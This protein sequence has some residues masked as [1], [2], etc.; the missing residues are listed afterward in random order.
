MI[1]NKL[2]FK[3]INIALFV[4]IVFLMYQT[5][6]LWLGILVKLITIAAPFFFAFAA[7]YA[8]NPCVRFLRDKGIP[9]WLS[10]IQTLATRSR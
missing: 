5:S 4:L 1:K 2:D 8:L 6:G 7:S 3:L 9:K 10:I